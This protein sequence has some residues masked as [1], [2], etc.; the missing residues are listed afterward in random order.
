MAHKQPYRIEKQ[1]FCF[2]E[3]LAEWGYHCTRRYKNRKA[4]EAAVQ[5]MN[6]RADDFVSYRLETA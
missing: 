1:E 2:E 3:G 4:A 5:N 6:K